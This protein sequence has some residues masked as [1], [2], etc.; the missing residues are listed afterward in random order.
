[1]SQVRSLYRAFLR[2]LPLRRQRVPLQAQI[3]SMLATPSTTSVHLAHEYLAYLQAQRMYTTLLERYNTGMDMSE[4]E[5]V[6]LSA[7]RVGLEL[8]VA[9]KD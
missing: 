1:M 3:R 2:E 6:R 5:R 8:P 7:R 9:M 4:E